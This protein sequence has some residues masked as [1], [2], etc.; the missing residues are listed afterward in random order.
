MEYLPKIVWTVIWK[1]KVMWN[2]DWA[3]WVQNC[4]QRVSNSGLKW[5]VLNVVLIWDTQWGKLISFLFCNG[6]SLNLF[7]ISSVHSTGSKNINP[8]D[9]ALRTKSTA[10]F[11]VSFECSSCLQSDY[12]SSFCKRGLCLQWASHAWTQ[13]PDSSFP[14][15]EDISLLISEFCCM[16]LP[17][18]STAD[19]RHLFIF[20][21][22]CLCS[23]GAARLFSNYVQGHTKETLSWKLPG[24]LF[25]PSI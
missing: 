11:W 9:A 8:L 5:T 16:S 23:E 17:C 25:L 14:C 12:T 13:N 10:H 15:S 18:L 21:E 22:L 4:L 19:S 2:T 24:S 6:G 1:T 7:H 3:N 20:Q